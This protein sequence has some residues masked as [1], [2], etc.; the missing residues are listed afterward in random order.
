MGKAPIK[1]SPEGRHAVIFVDGA[2]WHQSHL[3]DKFNKL[4]I[5]KLPPIHLI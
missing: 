1:K 2:A 3:T 4:S 5:I